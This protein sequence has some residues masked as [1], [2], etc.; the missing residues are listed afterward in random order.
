[1]PSCLIE[2]VS[3]VGLSPRVLPI[4]IQQ[5]P[6]ELL[7]G[8][9]KWPVGLGSKMRAIDYLHKLT[10]RF[11]LEVHKA[12]PLT[13]SEW[14]IVQILNRHGIQTFLDVG[15]NDGAYAIEL[16]E[17]GFAGSI[18]S[19]EPLPAAW[20]ALR[21]RAA[22]ANS[23]WKVAPRVALSNQ[24][25]EAEFTEAGNKV[26]SSLLSMLDSHIAAAPRSRPLGKITV[27]T[28]TLDDFLLRETVASPVF[29]KIDVQG[30][31]MLVLEGATRTL[32]DVVVGVQVEMSLAPLY[33]GQPLYWEVDSFLR[34]KGF[35]CCHIVTGF[36]DPA[37]LHLLQFDGIYF[38]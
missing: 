1:V 25:G 29:L 33:M 20:E 15:A 26:S 11:G 28:M 24:N 37:T 5:Q 35:K 22:Q 16:L 30:A 21:R 12:N 17:S 34:A 32:Q 8:R 3:S 18:L 13:V 19:F 27:Q 10:R 38:R 23:R 2:V 31:E 36:S 7:N 4:A 9:S 14:R 6:C